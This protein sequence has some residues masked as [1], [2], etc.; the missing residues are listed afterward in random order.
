MGIVIEQSADNTIRIAGELSGDGV[1][2]F[3]RRMRFVQ[4]EAGRAITLDLTGLDI[5]DSLAVACAI[6][7]LRDLC[8]RACGVVVLGAPQMLGHNLYRVGLLGG[9]RRVTLVDMR[10]DEP[11]GY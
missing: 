8:V 1:D 6:N 3:E 9:P 11:A 2:E 10:Q 4:V 5:E 7:V